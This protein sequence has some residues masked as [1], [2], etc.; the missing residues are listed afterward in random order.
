MWYILATKKKKIE[1]K[2]L[3]LLKEFCED[4]FALL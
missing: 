1:P 4:S 2:N 3:D